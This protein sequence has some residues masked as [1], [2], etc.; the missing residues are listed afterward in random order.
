MNNFSSNTFDTL[1]VTPG[2]DV[3]DV[4]PELLTPPPALAPLLPSE[5]D[6]PRNRPEG[7]LKMWLVEHG[8]MVSEKVDFED[9][10]LSLAFLPTVDMLRCARPFFELIIPPYISFCR[11]IDLAIHSFHLS[12]SDHSA[13]YASKFRLHPSRYCCLPTHRRLARSSR[14]AYQTVPP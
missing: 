2:A 11:K 10:R 13:P 5:V 4:Q 7:A 6:I 12:N 1:S 14:L 3:N 8:Y 9:V